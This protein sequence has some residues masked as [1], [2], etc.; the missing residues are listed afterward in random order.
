MV[1]SSEQHVQHTGMVQLC[2]CYWWLCQQHESFGPARTSQQQ[3]ALTVL[4]DENSVQ[5]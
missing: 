4:G 1:D 5:G 3:G 2:I